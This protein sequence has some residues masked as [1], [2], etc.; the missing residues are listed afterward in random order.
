M[1]TEEAKYESAKTGPASSVQR[2]L[3]AKIIRNVLFGGLRY[4]LVL[5]IPFV[6]TPLILHKVG[7]AGYGTWAVFLAINGLT[8]LADLGLF[9]TLSKFVAEYYARRDFSALARL[10]NSG[11]GLFLLVNLV[12]GS[13]L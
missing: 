2:S 3:G 12:L 10:V 4:V 1:L 9:G 5:P 8:S 11:L 13:V 6:M 7:V